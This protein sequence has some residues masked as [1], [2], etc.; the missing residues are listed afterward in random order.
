[1]RLS[2]LYALTSPV[3][4]N[5]SNKKQS[6]LKLCVSF[7]LTI[8]GLII[9]PVERVLWWNLTLNFIDVKFSKKVQ[10]WGT[11]FIKSV[12]QFMSTP[13]LQVDKSFHFDN[14]GSHLIFE[15]AVG[16]VLLLLAPS[17]LVA[18]SRALLQWFILWVSSVVPFWLVLHSSFGCCCLHEQSIPCTLDPFWR[19]L[20]TGLWTLGNLRHLAA[21]SGFQSRQC[22]VKSYYIF[23]P[24][25]VW[26]R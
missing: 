12:I 8:F 14:Q 20:R 18:R 6:N 19:D 5:M 25:S 26:Q 1:M 10:T 2:V 9:E 16:A 15:C 7:V 21:Y 23:V 3:F 24:G 17:C 13:L 11:C 4:G 22:K